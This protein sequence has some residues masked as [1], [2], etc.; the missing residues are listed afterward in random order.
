MN[1][2]DTLRGLIEKA[3]RERDLSVRQLAILAQKEGHKIVGTTL[4][5]IVKGTYKSEPSNETLEAIAWLAGEDDE[6]AFAAAGRNVPGPPFA[7]ELPPGVDDLSKSER[8][9]A[10]E[11]LRTLVAQRREINRYVATSSDS[12]EPPAP[13]EGGPTQ[14][15]GN[16]VTPLPKRNQTLKPDVPKA[17]RKRDRRFPPQDP[18]A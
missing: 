16:K 13:S 14:K 11:I 10:I 12:T 9:A 1:E 7:D 3:K 18:E 2:T 5:G 6:V 15:T 4:S 8:R 17:A